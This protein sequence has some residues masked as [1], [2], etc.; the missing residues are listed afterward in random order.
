MRFS[1]KKNH[2]D[3]YSRV[4]PP[5]T[6]CILKSVSISINL[7]ITI[8]ILN[9]CCIFFF[10]FLNYTV[11]EE[12]S[13]AG[14]TITT[15]PGAAGPSGLISQ[16][17]HDQGTTILYTLHNQQWNETLLNVFIWILRES[18]LMRS[19]KQ[20]FSWT[21]IYMYNHRPVWVRAVV[22]VFLCF[23]LIFPPLTVSS[24]GVPIFQERRPWPWGF[25]SLV[26][27][28]GHLYIHDRSH[29]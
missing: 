28:F 22:P 25:Y 13:T 3:V 21:T 4:C 6:V 11:H 8:I 1:T 20:R 26:S 17:H 18:D 27:V 7:W 5:T 14:A 16:T 24:C 23:L 15:R 2:M 29:N 12:A 19:L 10:S 9:F